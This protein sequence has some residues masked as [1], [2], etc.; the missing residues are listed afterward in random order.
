MAENLDSQWWEALPDQWSNRDSFWDIQ[1][2]DEP[3]TAPFEGMNIA[4]ADSGLA[5]GIFS[6]F[7]ELDGSIEAPLSSSEWR[8]GQLPFLDQVQQ[9]EIDSEIDWNRFMTDTQDVDWLKVD[10]EVCSI[11]SG[12]SQNI[13]I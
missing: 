10:I 2:A 8:M 9:H 6:E 4:E 12:V 7:P 11:R 5:S 1:G 13:L 3:I